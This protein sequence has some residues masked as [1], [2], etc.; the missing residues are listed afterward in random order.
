[1]ILDLVLAS[2]L[3]GLRSK[4]KMTLAMHH[5]LICQ[6]ID[7]LSLRK[8]VGLNVLMQLALLSNLFMIVTQLFHSLSSKVCN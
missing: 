2:Y 1:M 3:Y 7:L 5:I 4:S 6:I 8:G